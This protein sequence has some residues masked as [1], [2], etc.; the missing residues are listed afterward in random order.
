MA[1][2]AAAREAAQVLAT[3][4]HGRFDFVVQR[5]GVDSVVATTRESAHEE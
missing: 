2:P 5:L 4:Q 3:T 1:P